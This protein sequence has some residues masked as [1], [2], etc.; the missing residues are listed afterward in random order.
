MTGR[1]REVLVATCQTWSSTTALPRLIAEAGLRVTGFSPGPL[2]L[3]GDVSTH[4]RCSREPKRAAQ[5]LAAYAASHA[6]AWVVIADEVLLRALVDRQNPRESTAWAPFDIS[7]PAI[8]EFLLSKHEFVRNAG[9]FGISIPPSHLAVTVDH[10]LAFVTELDYPVLVRGDRGFAGM[11]VTIAADEKAL[12]RSA[13]EVIA[14]YGRVAVQRFVPGASV[15]VSVLFARGVPLA[16]NAYRTECGYPTAT[17]ASTRHEDFAHPDLDSV[18]RKIGA[19]TRFHGMAG[20]DFMH[21]DETNALYAIE[22]NPRPTMGFAG[23]RANRTFFAPAIERFLAGDDAPT[24]VYAGRVPVQTYF[25]GYV[26][27]AITQP[28]MS[29]RRELWAALAEFRLGDWRVALW[30]F[31]RFARDRLALAAKTFMPAEDCR[32]IGFQP[33]TTARTS[34]RSSTDTIEL[35]LF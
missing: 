32:T 29:D 30:E 4:V 21:D 11:E 24:V 34:R 7:D 17:S 25:P 16:Y 22:V 6:F 35:T 31:G 3:C 18:V 19:A 14:A 28:R 33:A 26:F 5:E 20:I 2:G 13:A 8:G 15:S 1:K 12:R 9:R 23:T 10:A 27:F